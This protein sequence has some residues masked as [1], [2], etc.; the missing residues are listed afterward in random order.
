MA[1]LEMQGMQVRKRWGGDH[2]ERSSLSVALC[3]SLVSITLC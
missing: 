3:D 1:V 2:G